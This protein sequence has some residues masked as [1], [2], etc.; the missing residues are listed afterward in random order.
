MVMPLCSNGIK[1]IFEKQPWDIDENIKHCLNT[2]NV[3]PAVDIVEKT[4]GGKHLK[5]ASNIIF[6]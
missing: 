2:Y 4:Y 3:K 5:S 1:D 6:R